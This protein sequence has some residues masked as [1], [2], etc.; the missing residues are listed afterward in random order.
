MFGQSEGITV[1]GLRNDEEEHHLDQHNLSLEGLVK[2][3]EGG[4][5]GGDVL[6][7]R[8]TDSGGG[9]QVPD[10]GQ[11]GDTAVLDFNFT[12]RSERFLIQIVAKFERVPETKLYR[13]TNEILVRTGDIVG[14]DKEL[15]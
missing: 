10:H 12:P 5:S 2:G 14:V 8:E 1:D 7:P 11:L 6:G 9:D 3:G 15:C 4:K 13:T